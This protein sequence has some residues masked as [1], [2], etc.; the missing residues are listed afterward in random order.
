MIPKWKNR[1]FELR[2]VEFLQIKQ[3]S[4]NWFKAAFGNKQEHRYSSQHLYFELKRK[5]R[6]KCF[7]ESQVNYHFIKS[8]SCPANQFCQLFNSKTCEP[9]PLTSF[10]LNKL[11][12]KHSDLRISPPWIRFVFILQVSWCLCSSHSLCLSS[13]SLVFNRKPRLNF[14]WKRL[15]V[16]FTDISLIFISN[17]L[18]ANF[19]GWTACNIRQNSQ[20]RACVRS[21]NF[22]QITYYKQCEAMT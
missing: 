17:G 5:Y 2:I 4:K 18:L 3:F 19:M 21:V 22:D 6:H 10:R 13:R 15:R 16:D 11:E 8:F 1:D 7:E 12:E 14:V 20:F 9:F